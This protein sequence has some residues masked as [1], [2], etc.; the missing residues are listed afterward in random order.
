[1]CS[2]VRI[3]V[4]R[5]DSSSTCVEF[6]PARLVKS[7]TPDV[8]NVVMVMHGTWSFVGKYDALLVLGLGSWSFVYSSIPS[9]FR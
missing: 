3:T 4:C 8:N 2:R 5:L 9:L 6:T 1:M 7:K